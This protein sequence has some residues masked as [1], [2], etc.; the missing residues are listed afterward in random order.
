[1][2]LIENIVIDLV[3]ICGKSLQKQKDFKKKDN[4]LIFQSQFW[5]KIFYKWIKIIIEEKIN[6]KT[7]NILNKKIFSLSFHIID[8]QEIS[9]LNKKW[10]NKEGA[11][12]VLSFPII[13]GNEFKNDLLFAELGDIFISL[14]MASNQAKDYCHSL[15]REILFLAS[16]GFL[17][18][19]G[20]E[21]ETEE[22]L[23]S[24]LNFQEYLISKLN[25]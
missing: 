23:K 11:T 18:L 8:N 25:E 19:L 13:I 20:W 24:M 9:I 10:L 2:V 22:E 16:H 17:H 5:E 6:I 7:R 1:M 3:F 14:E 21:H 15:K 12:D 4:Q